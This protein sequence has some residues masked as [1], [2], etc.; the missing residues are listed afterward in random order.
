M[1]R[2]HIKNLTHTAVFLALGILLPFLFGQVPQIGQMLLPM[3]I[4][5][6]LC[7][8]L[9]TW[10]HGIAV[11]VILPL[12]RAL[13]FSRPVLYPDAIA[14]ACEMATYALVAGLLYDS[15]QK[16][17][18]GALYASLLTAMLAGRVVRGAAQ[19]TLL[20]LRGT[21]FSSAAFF[22][23]VIVAGIPGILLQLLLIPAIV[24]PLQKQRAQE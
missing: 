22:S 19:F 17:R 18:V 11:A 7:A 13:L 15:T 8:L 14:I 3:H 20:A 21:T 9:V 1:M 2:T 5:V 12:L 10:K 23:G 24:L 4:P 16:M 6:F